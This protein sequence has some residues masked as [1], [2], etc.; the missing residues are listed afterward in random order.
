MLIPGALGLMQ[1]SIET[2]TSSVLDRL[3]PEWAFYQ[4]TQAEFGGDEVIVVAIRGESPLEEGMLEL[5]QRI[6]DGMRGT[7]GVRRIDSLS[8]VPVIH[9]GAHGAVQMDPPLADLR[10]AVGADRDHLVRELLRDST[11]RRVLVSDDGRT[12]AINIVLERGPETHYDGIFAK[13]EQ[14]GASEAGRI[15][16]VPVFRVAADEKTRLE[17]LRFVPLVVILIGALLTSAF[18]T[19]R[20]AVLGLAPGAIAALMTCG[21]M[22]A[23][24]TSMT[25][26]TVILPSVFIA[27]GCAYSMHI[28]L[29]YSS[30]GEDSAWKRIAATAQPVALSGLTTAIGFVGISV[31]RIGVIRDI[32]GYGALGVLVVV[33]AT[34]TLVPALLAWVQPQLRPLPIASGAW[35]R[36]LVRT[37]S[38]RRYWVLAAW[39][40][41][42]AVS[43]L[44]LARLE[45]E[46]DVIRWFRPSDPI[47]LDYA[48]I[49]EE[50]S[51]IS[52][53]NL[54]V[55]SETGYGVATPEVVSALDRLTEELESDARVGRVLTFA[56]PI[57]EL[58]RSFA[59]ENA[60]GLSSSLIEQYLLVLESEGFFRDFV[61]PDRNATN[62][63]IRADDN[64]SGALRDIARKAEAWWDRNGARGTT[65]RAT[66]I[67][68]EFA[69]A[70][71][72]IALGQIR[73]LLFAG[74]AIG[75]VLFVA[76]K[77]PSTALASV[78]PNAVPILFTFGLMGFVGIPLDAGTVVVG[79]IAL[80]IA[81][82]DTI[83]LASR[84]SELKRTGV[85]RAQA[86]EHAIERVLPALLMTTLAV[87]IG[88]GALALSEFRF[89]K[90][91]GLLTALVMG[92][93][94]VAD[95]VLL[96]ALLLGSRKGRK[97]P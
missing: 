48:E 69:R 15:S 18:R 24:G 84:Y 12:A 32:G 40:T 33:G 62:V 74:I 71:D 46:T 63:I 11:A 80:G 51:G 68:Y 90:N 97:S 13:L 91:L 42:A 86:L 65:A 31:V 88:F 37:V 82:D 6:S 54:V 72:E 52:P 38:R 83:H 78:V 8:T 7:P 14:L 2:S 17:L 19:W 76:L 79:N 23:L 50:L 22:G 96:P 73:G 27:L 45:V 35:S 67:M 55:R 89:I 81:V 93:C 29:A 39:A 87:G 36:G 9:L 30:P 49:R 26:S 41:F 95:L 20:A 1:L 57:G 70:E 60:G 44:A 21:A 56:A 61:T 66:G 75:F 85:D 43:I 77:S 92:I 3:S 34:L 64:R 10:G 59:G 28:L 4:E 25:I 94:L 5:I 47:R 53:V 16:G 58:H